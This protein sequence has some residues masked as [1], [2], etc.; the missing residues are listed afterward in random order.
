MYRV[1][2]P[3][4]QRSIDSKSALQH[5]YLFVSRHCSQSAP[6]SVQ[7]FTSVQEQQHNAHIVPE[8]IKLEILNHIPRPKFTW[9]FSQI[10]SWKPERSRMWMQCSWDCD[11]SKRTDSR[12][13]FP[14]P[15]PAPPRRRTPRPGDPG[16]PPA[17]PISPP[18]SAR[19]EFPSL[20]YQLT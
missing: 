19:T 18:R 14:P 5:E 17:P 15:K 10:F 8:W 16:P 12:R 13:A 7:H 1:I 20:P 4:S 3:T 2:R 9:Y 6:S 11:C